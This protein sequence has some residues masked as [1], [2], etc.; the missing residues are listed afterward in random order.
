MICRA[1]TRI[2][3]PLDDSES[4]SF[5]DA[6]EE[7]MAA[8]RRARYL[9]PHPVRNNQDKVDPSNVATEPL[10]EPSAEIKVKPIEQHIQVRIRVGL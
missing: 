1:Q 4:D 7:Q 10:V 8:F 9:V 2:V 5:N 6:I 3:E